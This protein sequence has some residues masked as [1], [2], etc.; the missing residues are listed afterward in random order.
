MRKL[1][2]EKEKIYS[3]SKCGLCQSVC[4]IYNITMLSGFLKGDLK[5]SKNLKRY[6]DL[7]LEC[8]NCTKFCPS[9]IDVVD[10]V[11]LAKAEAFKLN[12]VERLISKLKKLLIFDLF[13]YHQLFLN[14]LHS[15]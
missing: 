5:M 14:F 2:D 4:P 13:L 11:S 7:C 6:L 1:E 15:I 10:I 3:C 12:R 9:G 8:G